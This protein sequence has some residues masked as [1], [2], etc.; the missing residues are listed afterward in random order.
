MLNAMGLLRVSDTTSAKEAYDLY[1]E[2]NG[3]PDNSTQKETRDK[4]WLDLL[5]KW[6]VFRTKHNVKKPFV[7]FLGCW[8]VRST[9][10]F[11]LY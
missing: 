5:S 8:S 2:Y 11:G 7:E 3:L 4:A 1:E 6:K 10:P 9:F